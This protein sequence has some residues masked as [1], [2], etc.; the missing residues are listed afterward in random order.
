VSPEQLLR[1]SSS[2]DAGSGGDGTLPSA[3]LAGAAGSTPVAG[4]WSAF[5]ADAIAASAA[6]DEVS[7]DLAGA[8]RVAAGNYEQSDVISAHGLEPQR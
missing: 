1:A 7:N 5:L 2:I 3:S 4:A 6:L 8:L